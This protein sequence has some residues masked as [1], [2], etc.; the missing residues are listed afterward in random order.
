MKTDDLAPHYAD[1]H[2]REFWN[3]VAVLSDAA[4]DNG[5]WKGAK[6]ASDLFWASEDGQALKAYGLE[7]FGFQGYPDAM[8]LLMKEALWANEDRDYTA[9]VLTAVEQAKSEGL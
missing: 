3:R 5:P 6:A 4:M 7:N 9:A 8:A 2:S 1:R